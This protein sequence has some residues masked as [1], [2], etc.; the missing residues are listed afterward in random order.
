MVKKNFFIKINTI[1]Y[2]KFYKNIK[3]I[4]YHE[5]YFLN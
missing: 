5:N 1:I 2:N 4:Y 3:K